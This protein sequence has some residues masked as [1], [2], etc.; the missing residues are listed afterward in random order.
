MKRS[1]ML[2]RRR[3]LVLED[4]ESR[5]MLAAVA[6]AAGG[7]INIVGDNLAND[8]R[9]NAGAVP[10]Q[11]VVTGV[12]G[13]PKTFNNIAGIY[14]DL[15]GGNDFF[16]V[17][18]SGE[19]AELLGNITV[20]LGAGSDQAN[21]RVNSL[22]TVM[23]DGGLQANALAQNDVV[24]V[25]NSILGGLVVNL[26]A[27]DDSLVITNSAIL[28]LVANL[29]VNALLPGQTDSD[30]AFIESSA[31]GNA[32]ITLGTAANGG[33]NLVDS[34]STVF[35]ALT[36][37]GGNK[38]DGIFLDSSEECGV[39]QQ[40]R[41]GLVDLV[42]DLEPLLESFA[43]RFNVEALLNRLDSLLGTIAAAQGID[44]EG[45]DLSQLWAQGVDPSDALNALFVRLEEEGLNFCDIGQQTTVVTN[46][47]V[48]TLAG[49]DF[50]QI[51]QGLLTAPAAAELPDPEELLIKAL[52]AD[53]LVLGTATINT[54][55]GHD[56]VELNRL[57]VGVAL[58]VLLGTG[59]D[60]L[61]VND[62]TAAVVIFDGGA[63]FDEL[64]FDFD[65]VRDELTGYLSY[66]QLGFEFIGACFQNED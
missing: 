35:G 24:D 4:L 10:G 64:L 32:A 33:T 11:F 27:G 16:K 20:L 25:N 6:T 30:Q 38:S 53:V 8:V 1:P 29:G 36:I 45:L 22:G 49:N 63:G 21:F 60:T 55:D 50:V 19:P 57:F 54:G 28:N 52:N 7:I 13:A 40:L 43:A 65:G 9:V 42:D 39:G 47:V 56:G 62:V 44:L 2:I 41:F 66:T 5:S 34:S 58:T 14:A 12:T 51:G 61:C 59:N 48:N 17:G 26:W 18:T 3:P 31:I 23:V 46:L 37:I 15:K